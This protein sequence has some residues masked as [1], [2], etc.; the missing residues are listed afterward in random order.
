MKRGIFLCLGLVLLCMVHVKP[1][2][3]ETSIEDQTIALLEPFYAWVLENRFVALPSKEQ[4]EELKAFF[5]PEVI[6]LMADAEAVQDYCITVTKKGDKPWVMEGTLLVGP[7][8]GA[9]EVSY[10]EL[11][12]REV[13]KGL[14]RV[15]LILS[16]TDDTQPKANR[17]RTL[18]WKEE[19]ELIQRKEGWRINNI[20]F[21]WGQDLQSRLKGYV[22]GGKKEC[23][24]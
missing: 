5:T 16:Y 11:E 21:I 9:M 18:S 12:I 7:H 1:V 23:A 4:R 19:V 6:Q 14:I 10:G 17:F 24:K 2:Q 15:P 13:K 20:A 3:A 8:E 22:G